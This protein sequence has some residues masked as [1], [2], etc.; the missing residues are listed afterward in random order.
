MGPMKLGIFGSSLATAI[1]YTIGILLL[2]PYIFSKKRLLSFGI[3]IEIFRQS[4]VKVKEILITGTPAAIGIGLVAVKLFFINH[5]VGNIAGSD[6]L[7]VFSV[8]LSCLSFVSMF[9]SGTAGTMMPI[10]GTLLGE[11]DFRGIRF[12]MRYALIICLSVSG[13]VIVLFEC[14]PAFIF[15]LFGIG[16]NSP[17]LALGITGLRLFSISLFGVAVSFLMMY[18]FLT[19][20]KSIFA[21]VIS[22]TE[23]L[24]FPVPLAWALSLVFGLNG[25]WFA[26]SLTEVF[27]FIVIFLMIRYA[28]QKE[29]NQKLNILL[30]EDVAPEVLFESST[31]LDQCK[32]TE[33]AQHI[34]EKILSLNL[35]LENPT[36]LADLLQ[37]LFEQIQIA[38]RKKKNIQMDIRLVKSDAGLKLL[39]RNDGSVFNPIEKLYEQFTGMKDQLSYTSVLSLNQIQIEINHKASI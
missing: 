18:Y 36:L 8:C 5:L 24:L 20:R 31:K 34:K 35:D 17:I 38:E 21:N 27:A 15:S 19:I 28:R 25:V 30:M 9:I 3:R 12:I 4:F 39:L 10:V 32:N 23:G 11:R 1:G 33:I 7:V 26:Y 13:F 2:I 6:G 14:F 29:K 16:S 22:F 37:N